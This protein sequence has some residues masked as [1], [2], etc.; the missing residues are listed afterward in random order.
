VLLS[1]TAGEEDSRQQLVA[2]LLLEDPTYNQRRENLLDS[3]IDDVLPSM[4][5]SNSDHCGNIIVYRLVSLRCASDC[6]PLIFYTVLTNGKYSIVALVSAYLLLI[7][8]W[9]P[10]WL[11][12]FVLTEWGVYLTAIGTIFLIGRAIIRL[13]AFPGASRKV[14]SDIETEFAKYSVRII[15]AACMSL[16]DLAAIFEPRDQSGE[17]HLDSRIIPLIPGLWRRVNGFRCRVLGVYVDVLRYL[18]QQD[19]ISSLAL[20]TNPIDP[21]TAATTVSIGT[22]GPE[23]TKHGNNRLSGDV[24]NLLSL[25]VRC[26]HTDLRKTCLLLF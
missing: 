14:I 8:F 4:T 5:F 15:A 13:I 21:T 2:P 9:L 20:S 7:S 26:D 24:G 6:T 18:Y 10:F 17:Q 3:N 23:F 22:Y 11:L 12:S 19:S 16:I 25:T 1:S